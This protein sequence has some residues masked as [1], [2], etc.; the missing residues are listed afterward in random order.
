MK[1][2]YLLTSSTGGEHR[3]ASAPRTDEAVVI[4]TAQ[5]VGALRVEDEATQ[6][7]Y[8]KIIHSGYQRHHRQRRQRTWTF[9]EITV[10]SDE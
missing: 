9:I 6:R 8:R 7:K 4:A 3:L 2:P 5:D 10:P 1:L